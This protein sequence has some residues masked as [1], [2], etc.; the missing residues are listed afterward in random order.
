MMMFGIPAL[1]I[2]SVTFVCSVITMLCG[3]FASGLGNGVI[4]MVGGAL[5]QFI[6]LIPVIYVLTVY[7][8]ID[9]AW[10]AYKNCD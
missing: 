9:K 6:V 7:D 5:R 3:Y 10:Y 4:N 2:I 1:R 8:G